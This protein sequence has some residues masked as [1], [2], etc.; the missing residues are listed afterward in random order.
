MRI[1]ATVV[2]IAASLASPTF[3]QAGLGPAPQDGDKQPAGGV[4]PKAPAKLSSG[5]TDAE[6]S[7]EALKKAEQVLADVAKAYQ[8]AATLTEKISLTVAMPDGG[9]QEQKMEAAYGQKGAM[10][11]AMDQASVVVVDNVAYFL[12]NDPKDK[13]V[14]QKFEGSTS[15]ALAAL[16]PGF[17]MP[18]GALAMREGAEPAAAIVALGG[19]FLQEAKIVGFRSADGM[20]LVLLSN[21]EGEAVVGFDSRSRLEKSVKA[22]L[23]PAGAPEGMTIAIDIGVENTV[24]PELPRPITFEK[25]Q[26]TAVASIADLSPG[27]GE[28]EMKVKAGDVAPTAK[29]TTLDGKEVDIASLKGKVVVLDFW[30]T[31]CGPCKK[32]LPLLE[33]FAVSMKDNPKVAV[34][35]VNVWENTKG[36]DRIKAVSTFWT[37]K[38]FTMTTLIDPESKLI[39]AYGFSGIPAFVIIGPDGKISATHIGFDPGLKDTLKK[40][41]EE[42]LAKK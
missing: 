9:K 13:Y 25:G 42:A 27:G 12:P 6:R 32:G 10:R 15:K 37:D 21:A 3:A 18:T 41:V 19:P 11:F 20:D 4:A 22:L 28:P 5:W 36:D 16:L 8:G 24:A 30:A 26:R 31:W 7:P 29:L 38:K 33:E 14:E 40:E 35:P 34:Y 17:A 23:S 1:I 39:E 2:A